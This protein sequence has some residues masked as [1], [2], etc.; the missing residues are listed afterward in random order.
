MEP[1]ATIQRDTLSTQAYRALRRAILARQYPPGTRLVVRE[2]AEALGLSP[3]PIKEALAALAREGLVQAMPHKGYQ[4]PAPSPR[5]VREIYELR[6]ALEGLAARLAALRGERTLGE[7][8]EALLRTQEEAAG[9]G[10]LEAYGDLDLAF[11]RTLWE[12][13][14]NERL[15]QAAE[16]LNGLVR[17][18]ISTTAALPGRLPA[19]LVEHGF[20]LEHI[21]TKDPEG[22]ENAMRHHVRQAWNALEAFFGL[23]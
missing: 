23:K 14:G 18:L 5:D 3:T 2:L 6:E 16:N 8:L 22:A 10:D 12:A 9:R 1:K 4:V 19:S 15:R 17:L 11:H 20:I 21:R 7:R 13:S